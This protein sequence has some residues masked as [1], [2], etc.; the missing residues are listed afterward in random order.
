MITIDKFTASSEL[1]DLIGQVCPTDAHMHV[2][3]RGVWVDS[4]YAGSFGNQAMSAETTYCNV[5]RAF[6]CH[7]LTFWTLEKWQHDNGYRCELV[8]LSKAAFLDL[9]HS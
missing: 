1:L 5:V 4:N 2:Q 3:M 7:G 9:I 8:N 6:T